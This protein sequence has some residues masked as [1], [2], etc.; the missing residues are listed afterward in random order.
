MIE[1][2]DPHYLA[3]GIEVNML[4]RLAPERWPAFTRLA[5]AVYP[6][7][8]AA[9]PALPVFLTFQVDLLVI[10][11][12][13][14]E[15]AIREVL[16]YTDVMAASSYWYSVSPDPRDLGPSHFDTLARL[17][18]EKPFAVAETAWPAED[19]TEPYPRLI[20]EDEESQRL[21]VDLLLDDA[22][23]LRALFVCWFFGRDFDDFWVTAL[24]SNP[25]AALLRLWRDTGLYRG[26]GTPRPALDSWRAALARPRR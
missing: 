2:F 6:R 19:V 1:E 23:R 11:R 10:D 13:E 15:A 25:D 24:A 7:L 16:P 8:K 22:E 14:Q 26:D 3:Y 21:Y 4:R 5:A 9:H 18:P 20:P 12:E 17:A